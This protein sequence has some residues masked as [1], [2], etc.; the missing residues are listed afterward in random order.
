MLSS[1][2]GGAVP[3]LQEKMTLFWHGHFATSFND[4]IE[5]AYPLWRQN[6]MFRRFALAPFNELLEQLI[7][8]PAMLVFLDNASSDK[9]H[10]NENFARELMELHS[11]GVG[12]YTENDVKAA[13]RALTGFSVDH[14]T[15]TY[16][17]NAAA[18][19]E[20]EKTYLGKTGNWSGDD[21]AESVAA[22]VKDLRAQNNSQRVLILAFSE[23]GRRV[24]ENASSGTD[25]GAAAPMFLFGEK[26]KGG[27]LGI[28]PDLKNLIDGD[29]RH[30]IDVRQVYADVLEGWLG[31]P[32]EPVLGRKFEKF[33][34]V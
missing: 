29:L 2:P 4:K 30:Q 23:F 31:T 26:I 9:S 15:W 12:N 24:G 7:R 28:A 17:Y 8:D 21:V 3:L 1:T 13:A 11:M 6:D 18:H 33:A 25:H 32:S 14:E 5:R 10:A 16:R 20:S 27:L 19:D 34:V 22:F